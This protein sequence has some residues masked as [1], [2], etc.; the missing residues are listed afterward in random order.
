MF[1]ENRRAE[2]KTLLIIVPTYV[3]FYPRCMNYS[4]LYT[5]L[6]RITLNIERNSPI[7]STFLPFSLVIAFG[8]DQFVIAFPFKVR[9]VSS[10][11]LPHRRDKR[12]RLTWRL[13]VSNLGDI[14]TAEYLGVYPRSMLAACRFIVA[15]IALFSH[16]LILRSN[17]KNRL[18]VYSSV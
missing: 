16:I 8:Y 14:I 18:G 5:R 17:V 4:F 7:L 15:R 13:L 9:R 2:N 11:P 10:D 12:V 1:H 3:S 6:E